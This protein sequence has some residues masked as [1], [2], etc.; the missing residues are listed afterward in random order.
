MS[1]IAPEF[2]LLKIHTNSPITISV[3][4]VEALSL[5]LLV[6]EVTIA[7][8]SAHELSKLLL[9]K[10]LI[11]RADPIWKSD[12]V[13]EPESQLIEIINLILSVPGFITFDI[14]A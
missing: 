8:R 6:L 14:V 2:K 3:I 4:E 1:H 5:H 12:G 11:P 7:T 13:H 10:P 9:A